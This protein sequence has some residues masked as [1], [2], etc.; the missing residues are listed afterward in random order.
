MLGR[1]DQLGKGSLEFRLCALFI[2]E[3]FSGA[4]GCS[5]VFV[6]LPSTG[7]RSGTDILVCPMVWCRYR[8]AL[9]GFDRQGRLKQDVGYAACDMFMGLRPIW[10]P[11]SKEMR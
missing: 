7:G 8:T 2:F 3:A 5:E 4:F 10:K 11:W 6:G 9:F 1:F